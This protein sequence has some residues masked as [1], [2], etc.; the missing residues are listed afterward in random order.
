MCRSAP[1]PDPDPP[2]PSLVSRSVT[3]NAPPPGSGAASTAA[4]VGDW[5]DMLSSTR[6]ALTWRTVSR[7]SCPAWTSLGSDASIDARRQC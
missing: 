5:S 1:S 4:A 6:S 3:R 2:S 7:S